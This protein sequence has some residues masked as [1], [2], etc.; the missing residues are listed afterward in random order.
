MAKAKSKSNTIV[1]GGKEYKMPKLDIDAYLDYLALRDE[2]TATENK[3]GLYTRQ[4]FV[5]MMDC[6]VELYGNQ[7]TVE[8]LK[9]KETGLTVGEIVMQFAS[10]DLSIGDEVN[11][12]VKTLQ[13]NFTSG[14]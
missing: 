10:V 13:E 14:G 9:D 3:N 2:I 4:Q 6:I 5:D 11:T 12:K 7:F 1:I 8:Q